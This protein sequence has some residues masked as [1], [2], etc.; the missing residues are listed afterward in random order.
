MSKGKA[1]F[2][3]VCDAPDLERAV[4]EL[5]AKDFLRLHQYLLPTY[6][7]AGVS[8]QVLGL[9]LVEGTRRY[10]GAMQ[11]GVKFEKMKKVREVL[12]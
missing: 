7:D 12:G 10:V 8:G 3:A 2:Q 9:L 5:P 4:A 6:T 1:I 11:W